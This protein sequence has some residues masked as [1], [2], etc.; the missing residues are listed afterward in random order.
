MKI[1]IASGKGG[2]GKT[3]V[4]L[5]LAVSASVD[6]VLDCDVEAPN[7]H[8]FFKPHW[9]LEETVFVKTPAID[10]SKCDLCGKCVEFCN[11]N[12]L[13]KLRDKVIFFS[14]LCHSCGGCSIVCDRGAISEVDR[15]IGILRYARVGD[16]DFWEGRLNYG[17]SLAPVVI[18]ALK[19]KAKDGT[20]VI[21][22]PPGN[23]CPMV[24]AVIDSDFAILVT[25]PTPFGFSD[26]KLAVGVVR[27]LG[28]PF[29][30]VINKH[31]LGDDRVERYCKDEGIDILM[32]IPYSMRLA[33]AYARGETWVEL[34]PEMRGKF[35]GLFEA[36]RKRC[37]KR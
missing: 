6:T 18:S 8:I 34:F 36:V 21:D 26:L 7:L 9:N 10:S 16:M 32:R 29:G 15:P 4:A 22:S 33:S 27:K 13:A 14:H 2:T 17:E 11:Y 25:E 20:I 30:V 31:G 23:T 19:E 24:E 3:S 1:A 12:A 28:I 37:L 5:N 35:L